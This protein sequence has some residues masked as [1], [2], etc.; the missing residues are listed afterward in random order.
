MKT[1]ISYLFSRI[2]FRIFLKMTTDTSQRKLK[3]LRVADLK[4]ELEKRNLDVSGTKPV[5]AARLE[6][7]LPLFLSLIIFNALYYSFL[8]LLG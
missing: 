4:Q 6:E 8:W 2:C 1:T 7:V 5:L 3:D